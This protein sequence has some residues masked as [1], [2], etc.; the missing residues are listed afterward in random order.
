MNVPHNSNA[1]PSHPVA[2]HF[3]LPRPPKNQDFYVLFKHFSLY[4]PFPSCPGAPP[5]GS[6]DFHSFSCLESSFPIPQR[7][8][9]IFPH[10][11]ASPGDTACRQHSLKSRRSHGTLPRVV[12]LFPSH[13]LNI[14][15]DS[16][17][18]TLALSPLLS[19]LHQCDVVFQP[20]E[21]IR[22]TEAGW[23]QGHY[24]LV[25]VKKD[26]WETSS[27]G[28]MLL[29]HGGGI[30]NSCIKKSILPCSSP[31]YQITLVASQPQGPKG[32]SPC[33]RRPPQRSHLSISQ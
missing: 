31:L 33:S 32:F 8:S 20:L 29:L 28:L 13:Q 4:L 18:H 3:F 27:L 19:F 6:P 30:S 26:W 23:P 14:L 22:V 1:S 21:R 12:R 25:E 15:R 24:R 11:A 10:G 17:S 9:S 5:A 7:A 2:S 16:P